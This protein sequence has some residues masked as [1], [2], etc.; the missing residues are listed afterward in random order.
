MTEDTFALSL[1]KFLGLKRVFLTYMKTKM[2]T[3]LNRNEKKKHFY[4]GDKMKSYKAFLAYLKL[5]FLSL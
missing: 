3:E 4:T 2:K 1:S 5:E